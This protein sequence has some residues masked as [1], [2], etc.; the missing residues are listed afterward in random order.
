MPSPISVLWLPQIPGS[1]L[2]WT[3]VSPV[4]PGPLV[5]S[6]KQFL[7]TVTKPSL[8]S[9]RCT[10]PVC[11]QCY[12]TDLNAGL[13]CADTSRDSTASTIDAYDSSGHYQ[14]AAVGATHHFSDDKRAVGRCGDCSNQ[15]CQAP[16]AMAWPR[17]PNAQPPLSKAGPVR[18]A[19]SDS[20]PPPPPGG[21]RRRW[22][23]VIRQD[24]KA[25]GVPE[26]EWYEA[27][28]SRMSWC[29]T[30][31]RGLE[32]CN[33][34]QPHPAPSQGQVHCQVCRRYFHREGDKARHKCLDE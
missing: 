24:L 9:G 3:D 21:P 23:D 7:K 22:R 10:R 30:Y 29:E 15:G 16:S 12:Y 14:Q 6:A 34:M 4:H 19:T 5:P 2:M 28:L 32:Q 26:E 8:L 11:Y 25:V 20:P 1:M 33:Q 18:L 13:C 31:T 17:G 27:A